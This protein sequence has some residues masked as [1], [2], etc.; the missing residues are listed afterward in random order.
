MFG[1]RWQEFSKDDRMVTKEK[2]FDSENKRAKFVDRLVR[3]DNF[4][5]V[6]AYCG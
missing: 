5:K 4:Y 2:F 6:L 1:V 3:K